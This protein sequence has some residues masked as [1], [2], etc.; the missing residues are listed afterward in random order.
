M[1]FISQSDVFRLA[2]SLAQNIVNI[3]PN[4]R[5][6]ALYGVPRGGIAVAYAVAAWLNSKGV[7]AIIV[8]LPDASDVI[9]DDI[10]DSGTTRKSYEKYKRPFLSLVDRKP[11]GHSWVV[12]PWERDS[13]TS[14][15]DNIRR[16]L[17]YCGE[18]AN[19]EGLLETPKRVA[20]AWAF[21]TAGYKMD[22]ISEIKAFAD[23]AERCDEMIIVK[24]IPIYSHCEHHM[25]AIIGTAT[26]AYIPDGKIVGLS[27][28]ARVAD[29]FARRLQV[30][31]RL[32][33]QIADALVDGL[34]PKG[35]GVVITARHLCMESRGV[36]K[37]GQTTTTSALR[38][39]FRENSETRSEFLS[40]VR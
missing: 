23:G 38:G 5:N 7:G 25:A 21:W 33:N 40:L 12:F 31:E 22:P 9:I 34:D 17:Q 39:V 19:R 6:I 1:N 14:I 3:V 26:I 2:E 18:D 30:Q 13:I 36:C 8:D 20:K 11:S 16:L 10:V 29:I 37:Q 24:D 35:V 27:K 28:L 32:T 4:R 15:E